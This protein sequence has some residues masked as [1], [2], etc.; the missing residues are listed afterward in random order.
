MNKKKSNL[1]FIVIIFIMFFVLFCL[2][3]FTF[4][5][6]KT[7]RTITVQ[8][9]TGEVYEYDLEDWEY[10][11]LPKNIAV[12]GY[13][14][15]GWQDQNGSYLLDNS[16]VP[17]GSVISAILID[18]GISFYTF[19]Y[20][21]DD[22]LVGTI[23]M[24]ENGV[25]HTPL[26][27]MKKGY[28][29]IGWLNDDGHFV[30]NSVTLLEDQNYTAYWA[31]EKDELVTIHFDSLGGS[32]VSSYQLPKNTT[33]IL[34]ENPIMSGSSFACWMLEGSCVDEGLVLS[35]DLSLTASW[36]D[37]IYTCPSDCISTGDGFCKKKNTVEQ[38]DVYTCRDGFEYKDG[39]CYNFDARYYADF[40]GDTPTCKGNDYKYE[41][42]YAGSADI[43][44]APRGDV[45]SSK[46]C[47]DGYQNTG[48]SCMKE[49]ILI[50][51]S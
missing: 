3:Y 5:G 30:S 15:G 20:L 51:T 24:A 37:S 10:L 31:N 43:W 9:P 45:I 49:E 13:T 46:G 29:F 14:F 32:P 25:L 22:T 44:C 8:Y 27:P 38:I 1:L 11:E 18:Q 48:S 28:Q 26:K 21:S 50:C 33:L 16:Y 4:F 35:K 17:D 41:E 47:P 39:G 19:H 40:S 7:Y 2:L 36:G 34:P 6:N 42:I 23:K 12:N